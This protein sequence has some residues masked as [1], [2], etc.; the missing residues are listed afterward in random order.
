MPRLPSMW[1]YRR[2]PQ[3][4]VPLSRLIAEGLAERRGLSAH[5][6]DQIARFSRL[7]DIG[8]IG[9]PDRIL[10]KQGPLTDEERQVMNTHVELGLEMIGKVLC[11]VIRH[12]HE[13][14][15]GSGH[16]ER[17]KGEAISLEG[18]IVAIVWRSWSRCWLQRGSARDRTHAALDAVGATSFIDN[19]VGILHA[20]SVSR[21]AGIGC[22]HIKVD[23]ASHHQGIAGAGIHQSSLG[24]YGWTVAD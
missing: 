16:P 4:G 21:L 12:H 14:L 19:A 15:D 24:V 6:V 20:D 10:L 11:N 8:K 1:L 5:A 13:R 3:P 18:R 9:I 23:Y 2:S 17:L 22:V 7:H